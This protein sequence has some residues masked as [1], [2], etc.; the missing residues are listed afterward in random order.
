MKHLKKDSDADI[1]ALRRYTDGVEEK[2]EMIRINVI[3]LGFGPIFHGDLDKHSKV[4]RSTRNQSQNQ[5]NFHGGIEEDQLPRIATQ[6]ISEIGKQN[7]RYGAPKHWDFSGIS[8][9]SQ[10]ST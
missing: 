1:A 7:G 5:E 9:Q 4:I 3:R 6:Q 8:I 2:L 10:N